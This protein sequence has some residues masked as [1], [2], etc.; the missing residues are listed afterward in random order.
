[1][2]AKVLES[3]IE[4]VSRVLTRRYGME[5][6]FQGNSCKTDGKTIYLPSLPDDLPDDLLEAVRGWADHEC[7]H[8]IFTETGVRGEFEKE[9]GTRAFSV[10]NTL[11]DARVERLMARSYPGSGVNIEQAFRFTTGLLE[12]VPK[13][14]FK[15]FTC[16][17]YTRA[18]GRRDLDFLPG[19]AYRLVDRCQE[20]VDGLDACSS[21]SEVADLAGRIWK[22]IASE[23]PDGIPGDEEE[24]E[25]NQPDSGSSSSDEEANQQDGQGDAS[26]QGASASRED[27]S[28]GENQDGQSCDATGVPEGERSEND[29][30]PMGQLQRHIEDHMRSRRATRTYRVYT[31]EHD[32][33]EVPDPDPSY[34]WRGKIK[35]LRP[36][37]SGLLRRLV[38]TLTGRREKRWLRERSRGRLDPGALHKLATERTGRIFRRRTETEDGPTACTLLLDLS[39]S[40]AGEQI[41][42][43]RRL[44]LIFGQTLSQLS[45][46][47]EIIGF[48][49]VDRDLRAEV[50][51]ETGQSREELAKR[52]SRMVPLYHAI[53]KHFG[54]PWRRGAARM[55]NAHTR[56]LTPM[57]ESLLFAGKRLARRPEKRKV[58]FCLTDG[59]PVVGAWNEGMTQAHACEVVE[60]LSDA[61]IEPVGIGILENSAR[62]IFPRYAVIHDLDD[63]ATTF[64]RQLCSVL[65]E[66]AVSAQPVR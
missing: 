8:A 46:P 53:L 2:R 28:D 55:G 10:L 38:H 57:G 63:L 31:R 43:C 35:D 30:S 4:K 52:Y 50:I 59:K 15:A 20:E 5:V 61:G 45:F 24:Q 66:R 23:L 62:D 33:V 21:T 3:A 11:E 54:E 44:G 64:A 27:E 32:V 26:P 14:P 22:K 29:E 51:R 25:D 41:R 40:M 60:L 39:S 9:F 65:T 48:S 34:D 56:V 12:K 7:A 16:A 6:V 47:T 18:A 1:M 37:V 36:Q 13:D 42:I 17:L 49:T 19:A 58:L